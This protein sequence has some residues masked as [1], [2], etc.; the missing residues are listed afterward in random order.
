MAIE[1]LAETGGYFFRVL[2]TGGKVHAWKHGLLKGC[3]VP[4]EVGR[5][6]SSTH[7]KPEHSSAKSE[8][9]RPSE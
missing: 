1:T 9:N 6:Q 8:D 7:V 2:M 5:R 3:R 4:I